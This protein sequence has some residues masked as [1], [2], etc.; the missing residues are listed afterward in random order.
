MREPI[1]VAGNAGV[2]WQ[3][4]SKNHAPSAK[5]PRARA[6]VERSINAHSVTPTTP[7]SRPYRSYYVLRCFRNVPSNSRESDF[8]APY[9]KLL[10]TPFPSRFRVR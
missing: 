1:R 10:Y 3:S 6:Q 4:S 9:N 8:Y 5:G 7:T 2:R